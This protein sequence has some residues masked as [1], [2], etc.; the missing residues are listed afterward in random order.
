MQIPIGKI[1]SA[2][3]RKGE[4]SKTTSAVNISVHLQIEGKQVW[5]IVLNFHRNLS[6]HFGILPGQLK[7]RKTVY[8]PFVAAIN[9]YEDTEMNALIRAAARKAST[10]DAFSAPQTDGTGIAPPLC[11]HITEAALSFLEIPGQEVSVEQFCGR[12]YHLCR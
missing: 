2:F 6:K 12:E 3:S 1:L 10:V 7:G 11:S 5:A 8:D 4:M 9:E